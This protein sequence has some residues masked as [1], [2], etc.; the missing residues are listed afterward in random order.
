MRRHGLDIRLSSG[1]IV[2]T[3]VMVLDVEGDLRALPGLAG[4]WQD[5]SPAGCP[6]CRIIGVRC[7]RTQRY[8]DGATPASPKRVVDAWANDPDGVT[9]DAIDR[10]G[11][12][13]VEP[14]DYNQFKRSPIIGKFSSYHPNSNPNPNPNPNP[15]SGIG[16]QPGAVHPLLLCSR[17]EEFRGSRIRDPIGY[18]AFQ[19]YDRRTTTTG[20]T[21]PGIGR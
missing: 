12:K 4:V 18:R 19:V 11:V 21:F 5:P 17:F 1:R 6:K 2:R 13:C 15:R 8:K 10:N 16:T 9:F 14:A 3:K 7:G 20:R